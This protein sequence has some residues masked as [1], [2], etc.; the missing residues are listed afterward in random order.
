M[1]DEKLN[2]TTHDMEY[3]AFDEQTVSGVE[4]VGQHIKMRLL[5][6]FGE[7]FTN[8]TLGNIDFSVFSQKKNV[9]SI[10]DAHNVVTIKSTPEVR[11][12]ISYSSELDENRVMTVSFKVS[13][14]YGPV[15]VN[16]FGI[17]L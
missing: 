15:A 5:S 11:S 4:Q 14:D 16:N 8:S 9:K 12:V 6:V 1:I 7:F 2:T 17:T 13:T 10:M 3:V